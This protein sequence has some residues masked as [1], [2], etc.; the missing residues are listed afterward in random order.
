MTLRPG[1]NS[2]TEVDI[3][4]IWVHIYVIVI[5][6]IFRYPKV[7]RSL[8]PENQASLNLNRW[9]PIWYLYKDYKSY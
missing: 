5:Y 2:L 4:M 7:L 6:I 1:K 8:H 3:K 9:P